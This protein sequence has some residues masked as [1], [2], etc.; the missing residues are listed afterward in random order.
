M[1][2]YFLS[3]TN[4]DLINEITDWF[5]SKNQV[6]GS[7]M[8]I[9]RKNSNRHYIQVLENTTLIAIKNSS[10]EKLYKKYHTFERIGRLMVTESLI[11][12]QERVIALQ[13]YSAKE[14][15]ELLLQQNPEII[16]KVAL[17]HIA[18]YLGITLETLSRVRSQ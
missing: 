15:Y 18:S 1:N 4:D 2:L 7:I 16:K 10:L 17:T 3:C 8:R 9:Y 13:F 5:A 14:R 11:R 12:L 6:I